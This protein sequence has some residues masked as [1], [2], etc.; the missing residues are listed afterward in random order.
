MFQ[1]WLVDRVIEEDPEE[2][3]HSSSEEGG[4]NNINE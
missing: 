2:D 3:G 4:Q 1:N